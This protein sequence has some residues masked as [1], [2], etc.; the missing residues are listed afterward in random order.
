MQ[1]TRDPA[2]LLKITPPKLRRTLLPRARLNALR[3]RLGDAT[4]I[5]VEAPAGFG[6]TSTL[7]Q[8]RA[9]WL[10]EGAVVAWFT[11]EAG[12][13]GA[14]LLLGMVESL[15]RATGRAD[16]GSTVPDI[17]G[18]SSG[19]AE[20][21]TA[22]L[23]EVAESP[24]TLVLICDDADRPRDAEIQRML[25]YLFNN[26]PANLRIVI[27][28]R[29]H[30]PI[31]TT[32]LLAHGALG[33]VGSADLRFD[34][35]E[36]I[37]FVGARLGSRVD[38]DGCARLHEIS[39]GWPMGLQLA[40]AAIEREP[41]IEAA[42]ASLASRSEH[43]ARDLIERT[44]AAMPG[45]MERFLTECSLL[46]A[47]HPALCEA[48][49][50]ND[51]AAEYLYRLLA[52][53]P[54][55]TAGEGSE[56]M[57]LHALAREY[58]R[59]KARK[60]PAPELDALHLRAET[61]LAANGL[62]AVAADHAYAA[63]R[64][65]RWIELIA[66]CAYELLLK[67]QLGL[68]GDWCARLPAEAFELNPKLKIARAWGV[69]VGAQAPLAQKELLPLLDDPKLDD[70]TRDEVMLILASAAMLED[71]LEA[72]RAWL[73][74][75][76]SHELPVDHIVLTGVYGS[77]QAYLEMHEGAT[78]RARYQLLRAR[79][80]LWAPATLAYREF[81]VG[82]S[83]LWEGRAQF[84]EGILRDAHLRFER[85]T[86]RRGLLTTVIGTGLAAAC[87][88][89]DG[90]DE[91]RALL[92]HRMD[93]VERC[94]LPAAVV[95]GYVT[96][97]RLALADGDETRA[98]SQLEEL[99]ALGEARNIVRFE[100][101]SLAERVRIHAGKRRAAQCAALVER[102]DKRLGDARARS[103]YVRPLFQ[104]QEI[105]ARIYA[106]YAGYDE[107]GMEAMLDQ[108]GALAKRLNRGR[109]TI[110]VLALQAVS[111][112][113]GKEAARGRLNESLSLA[114]SCGLV[115]VYAD[116]VP[117]VTGHIHQRLGQG[118]ALPIGSEFA[119][120]LRNIDGGRPPPRV[121]P[122]QTLGSIL[123]PK[124]YEVLCLLAK[125]LPN[126]RI[127][128]SLDVGIETVKWHLKNLFSKLNAGSREHAVHRART[129]G[130]L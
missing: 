56:W 120:R 97:A 35:A 23:A 124:E 94:A 114:E 31:D 17:L 19:L 22:L 29:A 116:T 6:K 4:V 109:E 58:F 50:H 42:I 110:Q 78:E 7:A 100:I 71:D 43:L 24:R 57:R 3:E 27:G 101:A 14:R 87:W 38:A 77:L 115:R 130:I 98:L 18:R 41:G 46:D 37:A 92:A 89:R 2:I 107:A 117:D 70:N 8:W 60:L 68:V 82:A 16:F 9:D 129:L 86:G 49:T 33:Q 13:D 54:L 122:A 90:R 121:E 99:G 104:L 5:V 39:E 69:A 103:P 74:R 102:M 53:T 127:A 55:V 76:S 111:G 21:L 26:A 47:L 1:P 15:R 61:W 95:F 96:A 113:G 65:E 63:G 85:E 28:T 79:N 108:A 84:A 112:R 20:A 10:R 59:E 45:D 126:K 12:D 48:L 34:L 52:E 64:R 106:A 125:R 72:T 32:D 44:I 75:L 128:E 80:S 81:F 83:Y 11:A 62:P 51:K 73:S 67:G 91:A 93:M 40:V 105:M 66:G 36:A 118:D 88:D 25:A 119:A 30:L 123:T